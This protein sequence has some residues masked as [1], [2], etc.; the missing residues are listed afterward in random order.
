MAIA[1]FPTLS[2]AERDRRFELARS[3]MREREL[4]ALVGLGTEGRF[5]LQPYL[6]NM[7]IR[8]ASGVLLFP[9]ESAP[10]YLGGVLE[11]ARRFDDVRDGVAADWIEDYRLVPDAPAALHELIAERGLTGTRVGIAGLSANGR[12]GGTI[13]YPRGV[14]ILGALEEV[15]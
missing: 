5:R 8:G 10:V 2:T 3:F 9:L 7:N 13:A 11:K 12:I 1:K 4:S 14:A 6:G 15:E